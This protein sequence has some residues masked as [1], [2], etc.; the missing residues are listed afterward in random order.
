M[1][2][3][4]LGFEKKYSLYQT[5]VSSIMCNDWEGIK[6]DNFMSRP[7][8]YGVAKKSRKQ[9]KLSLQTEEQLYNSLP[10]EETEA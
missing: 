6:L 2:L 9:R 3:D 10:T 7:E 4:L 5:Q 1:D 8:I